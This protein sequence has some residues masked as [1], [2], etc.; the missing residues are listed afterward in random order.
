MLFIFKD[1]L[2]KE[3]VEI[4]F[5]TIDKMWGVF[6]TKKMQVAKFRKFRNYVLDVNE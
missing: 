6:M 4:K 1:Q 2:E 5:C 3:S